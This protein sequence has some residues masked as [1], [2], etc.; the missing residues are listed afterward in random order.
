MFSFQNLFNLKNSNGAVSKVR[1]AA[2]AAL[3]VALVALTAPTMP[4]HA[5][6][7]ETVKYAQSGNW[8][9]YADSAG[10]CFSMTQ[11]SRGTVIKIG[12]YGQGGN[13]QPYMMVFGP[14]VSNAGEGQ[15]YRARAVF[16]NW[17][18]F[19]GVAT[20]GRTQGGYA[21]LEMNLTTEFVAAFAKHNDMAIEVSGDREVSAIRENCRIAITNCID[22]MMRKADARYSE[23][24]DRLGRELARLSDRLDGFKADLSKTIQDKSAESALMT[25]RADLD[26]KRKAFD[27]AA[28]RNVM[29]ESAATIFGV[30]VRELSS[31]QLN[32]FRFYSINAFA[33]ACVLGASLLNAIAVWPTSPSLFRRGLK[34]LASWIAGKSPLTQLRAKLL[35]GIRA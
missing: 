28:D 33:L 19:Q 5:E 26:E 13:V 20:G 25:A 23:Q 3:S 18:S 11:F 6:Q 8:A 22:P 30:K 35:R 10:G 32:R 27:Q 12:F 7:V 21:Y 1:A 34:A 17:N 16:D 31:D 14:R 4:A 15:K 9:I 2:A 24:K 29:Y